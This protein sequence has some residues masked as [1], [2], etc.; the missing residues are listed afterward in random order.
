MSDEKIISPD[1]RREKR[2]PPHQVRTLK[3]PVLDASG[4]PQVDLSNWKFEVTGLVKTP[5]AWT[6]KD[7][8]LRHSLV[9]ARQRMARCC[10]A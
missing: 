10:G 1:T 9:E 5:M 7:F 4:P 3:W 6:W 2:L 8:P